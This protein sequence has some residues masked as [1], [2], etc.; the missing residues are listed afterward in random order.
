MNA[1]RNAK[2]K[3]PFDSGGGLPPDDDLSVFKAAAESALG[4]P[5]DAAPSRTLTPVPDSPPSQPPTPV[6]AAPAPAA[7]LAAPVAQPAAADSDDDEL[8]ASR[9]DLIRQATINVDADVAMRFRAYQRREGRDGPTP[10]NA[11]VIFRALDASEGRYREIVADR[12]P[13]PA[14]GRRFGGGHVPGRRVTREARLTSQINYR[15]TYGEVSEIKRL[16]RQAGAASV[17][18]LLDA[19]LADFLP[20]LRARSRGGAAQE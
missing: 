2:G 15:P 9:A 20:P 4:D 8:P 11:E 19:V 12:V 13:Q 10:S 14:P 5:A 7:S 3:R 18:A 17:S 16:Q 6:T 1:A